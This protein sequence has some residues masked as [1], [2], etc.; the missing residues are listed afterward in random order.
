MDWESMRTELRAY[1]QEHLLCHVDQLSESN[2]RALHADLAATNWRKLL[3]L[4]EVARKSLSENGAVKDDRLKPLDSSIVGSTAKDK[5]AVSRWWDIGK[6]GSLFQ[7][8][9]MVGSEKL[10][11]YKCLANISL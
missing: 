3:R 4:S 6:W 10:A 11:S 2:Q 1:G 7:A 5:G 9:K 8:L